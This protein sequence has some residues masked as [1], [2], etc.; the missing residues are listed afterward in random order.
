MKGQ[1]WVQEGIAAGRLRGSHVATTLAA[2]HLDLISFW[3]C[4]VVTGYFLAHVL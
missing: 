4:E 1:Q 2:S 3:K